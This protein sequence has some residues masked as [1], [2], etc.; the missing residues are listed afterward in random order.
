MRSEETRINEVSTRGGSPNDKRKP[1]QIKQHRSPE[2][3]QSEKTYVIRIPDLDQDSFIRVRS[4][5][6]YTLAGTVAVLSD[7]QGLLVLTLCLTE[8]EDFL[9]PLFYSTP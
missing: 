9:A 2:G 6:R 4:S 5:S 3:T 1:S 8:D 7:V